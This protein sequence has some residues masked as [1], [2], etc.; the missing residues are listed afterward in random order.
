MIHF[1]A[2]DCLTSNPANKAQQPP[3]EHTKP[4]ATTRNQPINQETTTTS[5]S[6]QS[7]PQ[8]HAIYPIRAATTCNL[9]NQA[10]NN[11]QSRHAR[12]LTRIPLDGLMDKSDGRKFTS[13]ARSKNAAG[14]S[15]SKSNQAS[16]QQTCNSEQQLDS[17][18]RAEGAFISFK[19]GAVFAMKCGWG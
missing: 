4:A 14:G 17:K 19:R 1:R 7:E 18:I 3:Q 13:T 10:C 5:Q 15:A 9:S 6:I 8:Q 2:S 16:K 12:T 11:A